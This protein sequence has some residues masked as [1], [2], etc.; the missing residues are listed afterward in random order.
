MSNAPSALPPEILASY[1][2]GTLLTVEPSTDSDQVPA[3][4]D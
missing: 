1:P 2:S 3:V 4:A